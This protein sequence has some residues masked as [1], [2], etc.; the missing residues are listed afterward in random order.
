MD[1]PKWV[2]DVV[3]A[4]NKWEEEHDY[5][6]STCIKHIQQMIPIDVQNAAAAIRS[7]NNER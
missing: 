2:W 7:Y 1:H 6:K 5:D 3:I 4:I